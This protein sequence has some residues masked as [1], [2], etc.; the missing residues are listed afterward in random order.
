VT[1]SLDEVTGRARYTRD[2]V[3]HLV[4]REFRLRYR[5]ALFGWL[6]AL[7]QPLARLLIFTVVFTKFLPLG[8]PDYSVFL[9]SGLI[10]WMWFASGVAS[11]T[12]SAIDRRDLLFRPNLPRA[13]VPVVS[14][15]TDGLDYLAALPV[16]ALFLLAG[17]GIPATAAFLPV[18]IGVQ[19]M[20]TLGIG[21]A[22]CSANVY[23]R[24]VR[25]FVD[26]ALLL[27]FYV[28][29]V[30]YRATSVPDSY[31]WV[32]QVNPVARL[33]AAYRDV[34]VEGTM[35]NAWPFLALVAASAAVLAAGYATFRAA[36]PAF[37]DEL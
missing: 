35:P 11:A 19:L 6:W 12:T 8:I 9:F 37:V 16:L 36:C 13:A 5:R 33:V 31:R 28:T 29:P 17:P 18:L 30:F 15:L 3:L 25:L 22:L 20:L 34:L 21:Y 7:G 1:I 26:I 24:D 32:L 2:L 27:G 14:V 10:G 23:F 4:G